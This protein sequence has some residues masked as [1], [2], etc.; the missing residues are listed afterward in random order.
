MKTVF[1]LVSAVML[2]IQNLYSQ[3]YQMWS[4]F[5]QLKRTATHENT[6]TGD[7]SNHVAKSFRLDLSYARTWDSDFI[8]RADA[9]FV[10]LYATA[11]LYDEDSPFNASFYDFNFGK[12]FNK[13]NPI[14]IGPLEWYLGMG[15]GTGIK[16]FDSQIDETNG[17]VSFGLSFNSIINIGENFQFLYINSVHGSY[18]PGYDEMSRTM[19]E[20]FFFYNTKYRIQPVIAPYIETFRYE[21]TLSNGYIFESKTRYVGLKIGLTKTLD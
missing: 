17:F 15:I 7:I 8:V 5:H 9:S 20:F 19:H 3:D 6:T 11:I 1:L 14:E 10:P 21:S 16:I 4:A 2:I 13:R 18:N 12:S